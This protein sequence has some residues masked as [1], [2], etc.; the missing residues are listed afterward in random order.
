[1]R[2]H[3]IPDQARIEALG[4]EHGQHD[5]RSEGD[6]PGAGLNAHEPSE[7][8]ECGEDG[9]HVDVDH[10]PA[11]HE[12]E[13]PIEAR[14]L[15][16]SEGRATLHGKKQEGHGDQFGEGYRDARDEQDHGQGPR[17]VVPEEHDATHDGVRLRT[18]ERA[19]DHDG[20][21]VGG[22]DQDVGSDQE[23]PRARH[24][25]LLTRMERGPAPRAGEI[26]GGTRGPMEEAAGMAGEITQPDRA[27]VHR[28]SSTRSHRSCVSKD[29]AAAATRNMRAPNDH[30]A[31][32][33]TTEARWASFVK[34]TRVPSMNTSTM[35]QGRTACTVRNTAGSPLGTHPSLRGRSM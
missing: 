7:L 6:G 10:G 2:L 18:E 20:E 35:P 31:T 32:P 16:R 30:S 27:H 34:A 11:A 9:R 15:L 13:Y 12:L 29:A 3:R 22:H 21:D 14:A 23:R 17:A 5:H 19:R 25:V 26:V 8:D 24:A 4:G 28:S 1:M 33:G